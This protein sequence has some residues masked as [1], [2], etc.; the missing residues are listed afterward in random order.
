MKEPKLPAQA[1]ALLNDWPLKEPEWEAFAT[2]IVERAKAEPARDGDDVFCAPLPPEPG[3]DGYEPQAPL[4]EAGKS[5][6]RSLAE[7]ARASVKRKNEAA[8]DIALES[9]LVASRERASVEGLAE[10]VQAAAKPAEKPAPHVAERVPPPEA[11]V[12]EHRGTPSLPPPSAPSVASTRGPW[13][14]SGIAALAAAAALLLALKKSE[15]AP[16]A[17]V[18]VPPAATLKSATDRSSE[19]TRAEGSLPSHAEPSS[20]APAKTSEAE[21]SAT[22]ATAEAPPAPATAA[23]PSAP[24][25]L[26]A[27]ESASAASSASAPA[28]GGV[29]PEAVV[30]EDDEPPAPATPHPGAPSD[31]LRP[32]EMPSSG[33]PDKPATG[34]VNAAIGSVM[35]AARTCVAGHMSPSTARIVFGSDGTVQSV[36]VSGAAAGTPAATC[37]ESALKRARVQ[38]FAAPSFGISTTIR[39]N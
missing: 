25:R 37:I 38:P 15:P 2:R 4:T 20:P 34:A 13:I 19:L 31:K 22:S 8:K 28:S 26:A 23:P 9:L 30:L 3:E 1:E 29:K 39:P 17:T 32:A 5:P 35:G 12:E 36:T 11:W 7:L 18:V 33:L 24:K 14:L 21:A 6:P 27:G 16:L 10:R